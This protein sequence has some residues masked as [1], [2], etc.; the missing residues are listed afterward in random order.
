MTCSTENIPTTRVPLPGAGVSGS[1][2]DLSADNLANQFIESVVNESIQ[3]ASAPVNIYKLLG[4]YEQ[5]RLIDLTGKG[6]AIASGE[7]PEF[8]ANNVIMND[9]TEWRSIQRGAL[10]LSSAYIGY[11][12]GPFILEN[13]RV[14][15]GIDTEIKYHITSIMIQQ[16]CNSVNRISQARVERSNDGVKWYGVD[17]ITLSN[18]HDGHWIDIKQSAPSRF[19]RIKP[20][21][22]N[23]GV[24]DFWVIRR[25]SLSEYL[26]TDITNVQDELGFLENRDRSYSTEP[27]TTKG[28]YDFVEVQTELSRYGIE[29]TSQFVFKFGFSS[30]INALGRPIVIGDILEIPSETQY[31]V[32]MKPVKKFIEVTDVSWATT[33]FTPGWMPTLYNVIAQPMI[34]NQETQ[35]IVGDLNLPS[36]DNDFFNLKSSI[37]NMGNQDASELVRAA[38]NTE[39]PEVGTD[40]VDEGIIPEKTV[41]YGL[42]QGVD[43]GKLNVDQRSL[44]IEDGLPPNGEKYTEGSVFPTDPADNDYHRM[45]YEG[46]RDS[47]PPRLYRYSLMKM[48]WMFM[49]EDKRMRSNSRKPQLTPYVDNGVDVTTIGK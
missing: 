19:W 36:T 22:F 14:R 29:L 35:D 12:F 23:G 34:A 6:K 43:L 20:L 27:V 21:V 9:V 13:D 4:I 40:T 7:Y 31:D 26:K 1:P 37:F 42:I 11:D 8:V 24:N 10:I 46:L 48:R 44:Y 45:T 2:F 49:E 18:D 32:H 16:G 30:I 47:V 28:Y 15:Y 38:A 5:D 39:V 3:I 33:G 25:L 17:L 41:R